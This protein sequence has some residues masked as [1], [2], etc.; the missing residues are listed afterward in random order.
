MTLKTAPR[1]STAC[2]VLL[3]RDFQ[4]PGRHCWVRRRPSPG[5]GRAGT[6]SASGQLHE[7]REGRAVVLR[8]E[9]RLDPRA[10]VVPLDDAVR[11][12]VRRELHVL[13]RSEEHTSDLQSL[14][15][16]SYAV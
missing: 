5:W 11:G 14:M 7:R 8:G 12:L 10:A 16:I 15:R 2:M 9:G 1:P 6:T 13:G 3:L 4:G